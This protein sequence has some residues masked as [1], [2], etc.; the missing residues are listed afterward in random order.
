MSLLEELKRRNVIRVATAYIVVAWLVIQVVETI[1]PAFGFSDKAV[2][3]VVILF[4]IGFIPAVIAA[5]IFEL[6]PG[7][8]KRDSEIDSSSRGAG[9]SARYLDRTII[10]VLV[11]GISFFAF[12]KFLLAP[13]R[14]LLR[15]AEIAQ[16]ARS[17]AVIGFYGDRSIAVLPFVNMSSD[18]EQEY[19]GDGIAEEILNILANIRELRVI[20]RS[21]AFTFKGRGLE[22]PEIARQLDVAHIL[23]GSVRKSGSKIRVTA[24]LIEARTDTHLWS[25]TYDR[26]LADVFL[27]QDEIAADVVKNLHLKLLSP[28]PKS[29]PTDPEILA[30]VQQTK[31]IET[32]RLP[33]VGRKMQQLLDQA[34]A[35]D[36]DYVPALEWMI[37]AAFFQEQNGDISRDEQITWDKQLKQRI[38]EL[39][40]D[41]GLVLAANAFDATYRD[42]DIERA[43][44]LF[45]KALSRRPHDANI[46]R[47]AGWY[48]RFIG[49]MEL[50][51]RL[52]ELSTAV[53]PLCYQCLH[54]L[55]RTY[56]VTGQFEKAESTRARYLAVAPGGYFHYALMKL[57]QGDAVAAL[58]VV[59]DVGEEGTQYHSALAMINFTMGNITEAESH[60]EALQAMEELGA[61]MLV[62]QVGA[63]MNRIDL[64]FERLAAEAEF[65]TLNVRQHVFVPTFQNLHAD[66]RWATWR[67]SIGMS[68]ARLAA[69]DFNPQLPE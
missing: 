38:L 69:I 61:E 43:A 63:W 26:E 41:N 15:E 17:D 45:S 59:K 2:R 32:M 42:G 50:A 11:L 30:L 8:L 39:D 13:D 67:E 12:D 46:A 47:V 19:F 36:P 5:W 55:S 25:G 68:E 44:V 57:F 60:F 53:D 35:I 40:P 37:Y 16:Q 23:E 9:V 21:S 64:A 18:P 34:L 33:Q 54:Q 10:V 66:P 28:L 20:S 65:D 31:Q 7:G 1:F 24:Q 56:F 29:K 14:A 3:V 4:G 49:R 48:A 62:P 27:I 58:E 22:V 52:G 6:T 51:T